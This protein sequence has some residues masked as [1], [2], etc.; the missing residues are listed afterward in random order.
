MSKKNQPQ[1][2][3]PSEAE[4][5]ATLEGRVHEPTDEESE[6]INLK[7][8]FLW[9]FLAAAVIFIFIGARSANSPE[10]KARIHERTVI[11]RCWH[12]YET[13]SHTESTKRFI[14]NTC[15]ELERRFVAAHGRRP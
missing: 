8:F 14:A 12:D 1:T 6:P 2:K 4:I 3:V 5:A 10:G 7:K 11:E 15:E 13:K 9:I